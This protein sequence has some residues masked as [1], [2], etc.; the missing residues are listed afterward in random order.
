MDHELQE[1]TIIPHL[2]Q[3]SR[4]VSRCGL[5]LG[6][7]FFGKGMDTPNGPT[8]DPVAELG[9]RVTRELRSEDDSRQRAFARTMFLAYEQRK[10]AAQRLRT[11]I[12]TIARKE[13][14]AVAAAVCD[15][16]T[17]MARLHETRSMVDDAFDIYRSHEAEYDLR[18]FLFVRKAMFFADCVR[19]DVE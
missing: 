16:N 11:L 15:L 1:K 2:I 13:P 12:R 5:C 9:S 19:Q 4:N 8:D 14:G 17:E 7:I 18:Y 10:L 6:N 3:N